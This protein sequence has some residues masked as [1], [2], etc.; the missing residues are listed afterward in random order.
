M[1]AFSSGAVH[2]EKLFSYF[3]VPTHLSYCWQLVHVSYFEQLLVLFTW[4]KAILFGNF[5]FSIKNCLHY[6][7][8]LIDLSICYDAHKGFS[9]DQYKLVAYKVDDAYNYDSADI[10]KDFVLVIDF[11]VYIRRFIPSSFFRE[12]CREILYFVNC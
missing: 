10:K 8:F 4:T 2:L 5:F 11:V 7:T 12:P 6:Y 1:R 9:P 3:F